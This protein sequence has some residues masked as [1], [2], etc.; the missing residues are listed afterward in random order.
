MR[1]RKIQ[2]AVVIV[3]AA[4]CVGIA[5]LEVSNKAAFERNCRAARGEP[6]SLLTKLYSQEKAFYDVHGF[7]TTDLVAIGWIPESLPLYFYGFRTAAPPLPAPPESLSRYDPTR[8]DTADATLL[9]LHLFSNKRAVRADGAPLSGLDLPIEARADR[10]H[11]VAAAV[12]NLDSD[13]TLDTW[14]IDDQANLR[15]ARDDCRE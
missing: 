3:F 2:I 1:A 13:G 11:F 7:Y 14:L 12:G 10:E 4:A 5:A 6:K 8:K 15:L 9:G